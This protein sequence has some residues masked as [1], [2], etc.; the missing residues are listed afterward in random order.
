MM[1]D[2]V[3]E[4]LKDKISIA[5]KTIITQAK[6]NPPVIVP[7]PNLPVLSLKEEPVIEEL[8]Q[9]Q[10]ILKPQIPA[11]VKTNTTEIAAKQTSP[12]LVV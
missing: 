6:P 8:P 11:A 7:K 10:P 9:P 5:P 3:R 12:T 4:E 2:S 1:N